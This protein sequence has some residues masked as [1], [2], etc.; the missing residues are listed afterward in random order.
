MLWIKVLKILRRVSYILFNFRDGRIYHHDVTAR[1]SLIRLHITNRIH[2]FYELC[3]QPMLFIPTFSV[4]ESHTQEV[5]GLKWSP[6]ERYLTSGG[7]DALVN[8]WE[9]AQVS[10]QRAVYYAILSNLK[11]DGELFR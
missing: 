10:T 9:S 11:T 3:L 5:C 2:S 7:S 4:F 1:D 6:D 8:V